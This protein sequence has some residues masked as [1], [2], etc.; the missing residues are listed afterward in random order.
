MAEYQKGESNQLILHF[1]KSV[2]A[3]D[4][5]LVYKNQAINHFAAELTGLFANPQPVKTCLTWIQP[6]KAKSDPLYDNRL[7]LVAKAVCKTVQAS[8]FIC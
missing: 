5:Q 6:S 2:D 3:P 4:S 8:I 7:K 1:K